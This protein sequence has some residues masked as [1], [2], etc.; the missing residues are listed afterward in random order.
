MAETGLKITFLCGIGVS[1]T[2]LINIKIIFKISCQHFYYFAFKNK[3]KNYFFK[4]KFVIQKR[5]NKSL[6]S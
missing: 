2:I 5:V 6:Y 3:L 1:L 4:N